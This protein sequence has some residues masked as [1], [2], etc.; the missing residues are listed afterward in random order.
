M[1]GLSLTGVQAEGWERLITRSQASRELCWDPLV[2]SQ[3]LACVGRQ[4]K[5]KKKREGV[6]FVKTI[7]LVK[8]VTW[9]T[10]LVSWIALCLA[11]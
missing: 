8:L 3:H 11:F 9:V 5:R 7:S 1:P 4:L 10:R 6:L 2:G